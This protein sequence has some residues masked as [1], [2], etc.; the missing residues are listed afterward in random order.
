[1][2]H[3]GQ[4]L[5][6]LI[7]GKNKDSSQPVNEGL[8]RALGKQILGQLSD[9]HKQG[10][11][12]RD[13]KPDNILIDH[14][15]KAAL[16]DFGLAEQGRTGAPD[17]NN[18]YGVIGTPV[19]M[20]PEVFSQ[21]SYSMKADSWSA[22]MVL[23]QMLT[24]QPPVMLYDG[25]SSGGQK[26]YTFNQNKYNEFI[27]DI[28]S[29]P[30]LSTDAKELILGMLQIDP[31]NRLSAEQAHNHRFFQTPKLSYSELQTM[32][33]MKF[34]ELALLETR[35]ELAH[36]SNAI[37]TIEKYEK[38]VSIV[39]SEVKSL[40]QKMEIEDLKVSLQSMKKKL[41]K[42][43]IKSFLTSKGKQD[44]NSLTKQYNLTSIELNQQELKAH[45]QDIIT[46]TLKELDKE[47]QITGLEKNIKKLVNEINIINSKI[48][49]FKKNITA[50]NPNQQK[51]FDDITK[52][53]NQKKLTLNNLISQ[54]SNIHLR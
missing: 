7:Y 13:L 2:K 10:A 11:I 15:G 46:N 8:C 28:S 12:H 29:D 32:H 3:G 26:T 37:K 39:G 18:F 35:L 43:K 40:Q 33:Q 17:N 19:Y 24:G 6:K 4:E 54:K 23:A 53:K 38:A 41:K 27:S 25:V 50:L 22:G 44:F 34:R 1:M 52:I 42:M 45:T 47:Q 16:A 31:V 20:A 51:E 9:L 21:P 14:R 49:Y 5:S 36:T 48:N 30:K